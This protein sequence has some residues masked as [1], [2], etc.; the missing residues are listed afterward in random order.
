MDGRAAMGQYYETQNRK[1]HGEWGRFN[2]KYDSN[3]RTW[4][5]PPFPNWM[6]L[7]FWAIVLVVFLKI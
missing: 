3:N 4:V 2:R 1:N 7:L 6:K 5:G